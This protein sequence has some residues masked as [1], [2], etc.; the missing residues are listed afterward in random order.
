MGV[1]GSPGRD[2][3]L[4]YVGIA[5]ARTGLRKRL[6]T[7]VNGTA[8]RSTLRLTLAAIG[9]GS[10]TVTRSGRSKVSLDVAYE[11]AITTWIRDNFTVSWVA[12]AEAHLIERSVIGLLAPPLNSAFKSHHAAY[13][14]VRNASAALRARAQSL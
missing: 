14:T 7:H 8:R 6:A 11:T 1:V 5:S 2:G 12:A 13:A 4:F 10:G 9:V 3:Y